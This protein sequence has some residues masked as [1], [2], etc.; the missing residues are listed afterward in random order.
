[1]EDGMRGR[2]I[3][4]DV[5]PMRGSV[6]TKPLEKQSSVAA[7]HP[8]IATGSRN[9]NGEPTKCTHPKPPEDARLHKAVRYVYLTWKSGELGTTC[10]ELRYGELTMHS[11]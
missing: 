3:G 9:R 8:V 11:R 5:L 10:G 4:V 1:M 7:R 2:D 6:S